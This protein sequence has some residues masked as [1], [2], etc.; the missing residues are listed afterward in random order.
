MDYNLKTEWK[1]SKN[2]QIYIIKY[3]TDCALDI[4]EILIFI[5]SVV[6][7]QIEIMRYKGVNTGNGSGIC[8]SYYLYNAKI[9]MK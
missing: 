7:E 3:L 9:R 1:S 8:K 4:S 2:L 6:E 5:F